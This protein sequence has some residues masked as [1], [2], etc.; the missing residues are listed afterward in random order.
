MGTSIIV[1]LRGVQVIALGESDW[2]AVIVSHMMVG[3]APVAA[4]QARARSEIIERRRSWIGAKPFSGQDTR[5]WWRGL[6]LM[7]GLVAIYL[8]VIALANILLLAGLFVLVVLVFA[9]RM[10]VASI[11]LIT[12]VMSLVIAIALV[13]SM[14][15]AILAMMLPVTWV[16]AA[17]DRKMSHLLLFWPFLLLYLLKDT[18]FPFMDSSN[19][20][21]N[22][23]F[24][25]YLR[26]N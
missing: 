1:V 14:V 6:V 16:T 10:I 21:N 2:L 18:T 13:A 11:V 22:T 20:Y 19:I 9:T 12:I 26:G 23:I 8:E 15:V 25:G 4:A 17:W 7:H 5:V 24:Y 3:V